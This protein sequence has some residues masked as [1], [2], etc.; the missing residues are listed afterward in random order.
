MYYYGW[1]NVGDTTEHSLLSGIRAFEYRFGMLPE[2]V[3]VAEEVTVPG[4]TVKRI[5]WVPSNTFY[6]GP[7][8]REQVA[9]RFSEE[10]PVYTVYHFTPVKVKR[11]KKG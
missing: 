9:N 10:Y 2:T 11:G 3:L 5:E 4:V 8:T 1:Y 6:M 7:L